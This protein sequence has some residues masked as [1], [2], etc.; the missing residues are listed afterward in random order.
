MKQAAYSV[1]QFQRDFAAAFASAVPRT[2]RI[3]R[4]S[5]GSGISDSTTLSCSCGAR[6]TAFEYQ[7]DMCNRLAAWERAHLAGAA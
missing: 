2:H 4:E 3:T 5:T 6:F 7:N 1:E